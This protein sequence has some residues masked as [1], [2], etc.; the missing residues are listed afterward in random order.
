MQKAQQF[1][2]TG[3][4]LTITAR[5]TSTNFVELFCK[6]VFFSKCFVETGPKLYFYLNIVLYFQSPNLNSL[7]RYFMGQI[8]CQELI[9]V[10][11]HC[12]EEQ[13]YVVHLLLA[14]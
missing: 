6:I 5:F 14:S 13:V 11:V 8:M 1:L 10:A 12:L 9:F 4:K 7:L 3:P 2:L